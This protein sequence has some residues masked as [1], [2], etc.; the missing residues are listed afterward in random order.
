MKQEEEGRRGTRWNMGRKDG[1]QRE[2]G[3]NQGEIQ[4]GQGTG[5]GERKKGRSKE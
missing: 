5:Q 2:G 1:E 4:A 3:D